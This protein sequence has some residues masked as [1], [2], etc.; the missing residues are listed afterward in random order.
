MRLRVMV[1]SAWVTALGCGDPE[2]SAPR[3]GGVDAGPADTSVCRG[4]GPALGLVRLAQGAAGDG[5]SLAVDGQGDPAVAY[6]DANRVRFQRW[7]RCAA[8]W[9]AP[10][11]VDT[12]TEGA[13]EGRELALAYDPTG[14]R[15][16][17][18]YLRVEPLTAEGRGRT[19]RLA[20]SRDGGLSF[21]AP[22]QI[23]RHEVSA[24]PAAFNDAYSPAVA[25]VGHEPVA[26]FLQRGDANAVIYWANQGA[27]YAA[28][29]V[30]GPVRLSSL[31]L[32]VDAAG[33]PGLA[34]WTLEDDVN[35]VAWFARPDAAP[36]RVIE[37]NQVDNEAPALDLGF[38]GDDPVLGVLLR[39]AE[40]GAVGAWVVRGAN[41]GASFGAPVRMP[42]DGGDA[43]GGALALSVRGPLTAV[44]VT[45]RGGV[46]P[47]GAC[48]G[49]KLYRSANG[50]GF[51]CAPLSADALVGESVTVRHDS[52]NRVHLAFRAPPSTLGREGLYYGLVAP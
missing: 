33:A 1:L 24:H 6:F 41:A 30:E 36:V 46:E 3:D 37:S 40:E 16:A 7:D 38:S 31:A 49:P 18:V 28:L 35:S 26:A 21:G 9:G 32:R 23:S 27:T 22:Q 5:V 42:Q 10:V 39:R 20:V 51:V 48:R 8:A 47:M 4:L 13:A 45:H 50:L 19:V 17:V 2:P 34:Y 29:P 12:V 14:D 25:F 52:A 44:A 43:L 11:A 15:F